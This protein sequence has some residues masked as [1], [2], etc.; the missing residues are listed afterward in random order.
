VTRQL[1]TD[2][3]SQN[4]GKPGYITKVDF[5]VLFEEPCFTTALRPVALTM[6]ESGFVCMTCKRNSK[7]KNRVSITRAK[8]AEYGVE[9]TR[10][11]CSKCKVSRIRVPEQPQIAAAKIE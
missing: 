7:Q 11:K 6:S 3:R 10:V 4:V 1:F 8:H 5:K 2:A 9:R